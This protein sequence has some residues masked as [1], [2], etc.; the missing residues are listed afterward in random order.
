MSKDKKEKSL[1]KYLL[2]I[3][4]IVAAS[5]DSACDMCRNCG[6]SNIYSNSE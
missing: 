1:D 5:G 6:S 2:K 3:C 4:K